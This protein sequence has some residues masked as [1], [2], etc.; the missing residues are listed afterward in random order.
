VVRLVRRPPPRVVRVRRELAVGRSAGRCTRTSVTVGTIAGPDSDRSGSNPRSRRS[1]ANLAMIARSFCVTR[2]GSI[3][4]VLPPSVTRFRTIGRLSRNAFTRSSSNSAISRLR[5]LAASRFRAR[6]ASQSA[7]STA[8]CS[9][10]R[11]RNSL[12]HARARS[13]HRYSVAQRVIRLLAPTFF[14]PRAPRLPT[15]RDLLKLSPTADTRRSR[16]RSR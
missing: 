16:P 10:A 9:S 6:S 12:S 2:N 15:P 13:V 1:D 5:R 7:T 11:R 3:I 8:T 14:P 4:V